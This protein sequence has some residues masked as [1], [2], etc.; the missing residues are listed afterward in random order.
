[1]ERQVSGILLGLGVVFIIA[2]GG[3]TIAALTT[4]TLNFA[5]ILAFGLAFLVIAIALFGLIGAIRN[6]PDDR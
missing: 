4:A 6:P 3:M 5:S 1:M 2:F